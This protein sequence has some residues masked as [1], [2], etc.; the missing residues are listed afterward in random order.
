MSLRIRLLNA[1][2]LAAFALAVFLVLPA[3]SVNVKKAD[4]GEDKKV[5]IE[6]PMGGIHVSKDA[7]ARDTGLPVYPGAREKEK[8]GSNEEKNANVNISAGRFGLKVVAIE[9]L[10][11]DPPEKVAAYY[12]D[13]LKSYG[14]ILECHTTD[15]H[16]DA[17][18]VDVHMG[19]HGDKKDSNQL[20]CEHDS[21]PT[22]ELKV[23][24]KQNQHIVSISP[25]DKGKGTDFALVFVQIH[26]SEKDMI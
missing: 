22:L 26:G 4:N 8:D 24:T 18:D 2:L 23:G 9:Y 6:T 14:A 1:K 20:T 12:K 19:R 7:K 13:Q 10:S 16:G 3:C 25:Q 17:G 5:D 11:D 15:R 21:G